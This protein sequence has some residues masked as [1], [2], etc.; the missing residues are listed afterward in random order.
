MRH[1]EYVLESN[2]ATDHET[3]ED[4]AVGNAIFKQLGGNR[5]VAMTGAKHVF[6]IKGGLS[7]KLPRARH[8]TGLATHL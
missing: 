8:A 5:F 1:R 7:F 6:A 2:T 3:G 4:V